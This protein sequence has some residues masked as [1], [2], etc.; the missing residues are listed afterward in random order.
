MQKIELS[1]ED[2]IH[3]WRFDK[4]GKFSSKSAY[5]AFFN[6]AIKF[7]PWKRLWKTWSPAKCKVF[8]WLAIRNRCCTADK[9]A[10]RNLPHPE[11]C[12]LCDQE[13][14]TAQHVL[15]GCAFAIEFWF[16]VFSP[17]GLSASVPNPSDQIF[18]EWWRKSC[19][20]TPEEKK[21]GFNSVVILVAWII[22]KHRNACV[23]QGAQPSMVNILQEFRD[24]HHLWGL[25]G[26]RGLLSLGVSVT[27]IRL[28]NIFVVRSHLARVSL[29]QS[30]YL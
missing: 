19:R 25:A 20:R 12:A 30:I 26:A 29:E 10:K 15:V 1:I 27:E 4:T 24:E 28:D 22:W 2:D 16:R 14:E 18:A 3:I 7:E 11:K 17:L 9:L 6:G 13:E 23:F 21:K 5:R 8:L